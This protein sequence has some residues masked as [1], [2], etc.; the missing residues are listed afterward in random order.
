MVSPPKIGTA[1]VKPDGTWTT[2]VTLS[3]TGTHSIVAEDTDANGNTGSS[4]PVVITL[5]NPTEIFTWA[6]D[7][8]GS[9]TVADNWNNGSVPGAS[10]QVQITYSD[11]TVTVSES[12]AA[13]TL[14]TAATL[15]VATHGS[16]TIFGIGG[17]S[18]NSGTI[19]IHGT[20]TLDGG[21]LVNGGPG[22]PAGSIVVES[23][24]LLTV[25]GATIS[26]GTFI[27]EVN[28]IVDLTGS[29]MLK[30]GA[31]GNSGLI[32]VSGAGNALDGET[33][34][35]NYAL[36]VL[37]GAGLLLDERTGIDNAGGTITIDGAATLTLDDAT[38][39]GGTI[40]DYSSDD[41]AVLA[42]LIDVTGS[43]KIDDHAILYN[44]DVTVESQVTLTLD[45]VAVNGTTFTDTGRLLVGSDHTLTMQGATVSGGK[46]SIKGILDLIGD[47]EIQDGRLVNS[48]QV[49]VSGSD[50]LHQE[51]VT[52]DGL[53]EVRAGGTLTLDQGTTVANAG[54]LI[55]IDHRGTLI[56][57]G[58]TIKGG[59]ID[60]YSSSGED[61]AV[62][63]G[64]IDVTVSSKIDDHATL[65]NGHVTVER[66]ATLTLDD[67]TVN[68]S[69][70]T[71]AGTLEVGDHH[72]L[73]LDGAAIKGGMLTI[74][75]G[76]SLEIAYGSNGL[77]ATLDGVGVNISNSGTIQIA[78]PD[79]D[80]TLTL[81]DGTTITGGTLSIGS[82]NTLDIDSVHG[83]GAT[84][85]NVDVVGANS[86][87]T[88]AVDGPLTLNDA[89]ISGVTINYVGVTGDID[90]RGSSAIDGAILNNG[91][92]SVESGQTLTLGDVTVSGTTI[93]F[94]GFDDT[95]KLSNPSS[96]N[97]TIAGLASGD[98]I[99]LTTLG[100]ASDDY[101]VWT[102]TTT[103]NGG[104]GTL[105]IYNGANVLQATLDLAG[106]YSQGDFS[107]A[108][109]GS[110]G[111]DVNIGDVNINHVSFYS[112]TVNTNG[113]YTPQIL[114]GGSSLQLT[115]GNGGEAGSWFA[116]TTYS[117][118]SFTASFD[119][120][121]TVGSTPADGLAFI[122]QNSTAGIHALGGSGGDLG[123]GGI[124]TSAAIEFNL[125]SYYGQGTTFQTDGSTDDTA[126]SSDGG[127]HYQP[128]CK[129]DFAAGDPMHVVVSY[130][131]TVLT[132]TLTDLANNQ[133]YTT[134]YTVD[135]AS[136]L[137]GSTAYVGFSAG[138]GAS[139]STQTVSDFTFTNSSTDDWLGAT[140]SWTD[141]I[142]WSLGLPPNPGSVVAIAAGGHPQIQSGSVTLDDVTVQNG[143]EI[144]V[145]V[146]SGAILVLEDGTTITGGTIL[147]NADD[148]LDIEP[149]SN[150]HS[151]ALSNVVVQA[152]SS[153]TI[154]VGGGSTLT[155][156]GVTINGGSFSIAGTVDIVGATT[157]VDT[158]NPITNSGLLAVTGG[159]LD[160]QTSEI[161]N[162]GT[163]PGAGI[164]IGT[165]SELLVDSASGLQL[166]G[167]ELVLQAD[168]RITENTSN[169]YAASGNVLALDIDDLVTGGGE[170]GSGTV[171]HNEST[172]GSLKLTI[173]ANGIIDASGG[174]L[175][176]NTGN[177]FSNGGITNDGLLEASF[178]SKLV[179][180]DAVTG[181]G[182][183]TIA[184]GA[185]M[186]FDSSVASGQT[187]T[188]KGAGKL[189]L[190]DPS[191][192][193]GVI[194]GLSGN[195][196]LDLSGFVAATTTVTAAYDSET[197]VTTLTVTDTS[198]HS[199]SLLLAGDYDL[200][201][202]NFVVAS[203]GN[204]GSLVI[205]NQEAMTTVT[206]T[207][208]RNDTAS[209]SQ[210]YHVKGQTI[211][212]TN[213]SGLFIS[214]DDSNAADLIVA[215][216]DNTSSITVNSAGFSGIALNIAPATLTFTSAASIAVFNAASI[217]ASEV[218][219]TGDIGIFAGANNNVTV[220]D[221][222]N[223]SG[224]RYG[225]EA[226]EE[227]SAIPADVDVNIGPGATIQ[228]TDASDTG[229]GGYGILA[230]NKGA[231]NISVRTSAGDQINSVGSGIHAVN[232][233]T[234]ASP[235]DQ[236]TII[237]N[238][239]GTIYSGS[240]D[241]GSGGQP[242]GILAG[243]FGDGS[244]DPT[245]YPI[246]GL[247]GDVTVNNSAVITADAGDGIRAFDYGTGNVTVNDLAG[248]ITALGGS[249][250]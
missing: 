68:G 141:A 84:L 244:S 184:D 131:G 42:G 37:A 232:E 138:T 175:T 137:D 69:K 128:T 114:N 185:V 11:I 46:L 151:V 179:I 196:L 146:T 180:D 191:N 241:T 6:S 124:N 202:Y 199:A 229:H 171:I 112:G 201:G 87:S 65:N 78:T 76:S 119:Y 219:D 224:A 158:V 21:M 26:G 217:N 52:N 173:E 132:E 74:G 4:A 96:F 60:D 142:H 29:A 169:Q 102:Q 55:T 30:Q 226:I 206:T 5:G 7:V 71:D 103:T 62:R 159:T 104:T 47:S 116:N 240:I 80:R 107:L 139:V 2:T 194:A 14:Y 218:G 73:T 228:S 192:F 61:G 165:A 250:P 35:V 97:G 81:D 33:V 213:G 48:Y 100:Y 18:S 221:Y 17:D 58:A 150:G 32:Q 22:E 209:A 198:G 203:D 44:G 153:G 86:S 208:N 67:V 19:E 136:Y 43:S 210:V 117:I 143:G 187:V 207:S 1:T 72:T 145:G 66:Q 129:V 115:D 118:A 242:A 41:E 10:D 233:A 161:E 134:E 133:T 178:G 174:T 186:E 230:I 246:L 105:Q 15:D 50:A 79:G 189:Y 24:G 225:I 188:F 212:A 160:V 110:H 92:V 182:K 120:Q 183:E 245:T 135:L 164:L 63:A 108:K 215:E 109:D 140:S 13:D 190:G 113:V 148:T 214:N 237:V 25:N 94:F 149:G 147:I 200:P 130:N 16:L 193:G 122:L 12:V 239:F 181:T 127:P 176:I 152:F 220:D 156:D 195:D 64:L 248:T 49:D 28:G 204:G 3:G 234:A 157:T 31:L 99:D 205:L 163:G 126:Y 34:T 70:F 9:W 82:G 36:E 54:G 57:D 51:M 59:T 56:L 177:L 77:G 121:A 249:S 93:Q 45:D 155:L 162:T 106:I 154:T 91:D 197:N 227:S 98:A 247:Y 8:S 166:I 231:G 40:D 53:L 88:I 101:S 38:I 39:K 85:T 23:G 172:S 222:G 223:V 167:G 236:S 243:Y 90:I 75:S 170:I 168:S 83:L 216:L 95:L 123:Y 27:N 20:L 144:D 111:T 235:S 89:T 211:S 238:A 125:Y